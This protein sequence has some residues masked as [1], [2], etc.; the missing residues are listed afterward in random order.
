MGPVLHP[1]SGNFGQD[2]A[3][4][5][6][7]LIIPLICTCTPL[8]RTITFDPGLVG[9]AFLLLPAVGVDMVSVLA[10]TV[11]H[12]LINCTKLAALNYEG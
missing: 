1:I 9:R 7:R 6:S 3:H 10:A 2:L 8:G 5:L 4:K 11:T 12:N